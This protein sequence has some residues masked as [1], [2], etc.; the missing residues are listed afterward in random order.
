M[1]VAV[2]VN[3]LLESEN[4]VF[5][6]SSIAIKGFLHPLED[7]VDDFRVLQLDGLGALS[8]VSLLFE[9]FP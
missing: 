7:G 2:S 6:L 8:E 5:L 3:L 1:T 9:L 4:S